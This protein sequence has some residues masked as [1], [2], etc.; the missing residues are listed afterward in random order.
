MTV[1]AIDFSGS[2]DRELAMRAA[3][4]I[5][6]TGNAND[7]AL[8]F[9]HRIVGVVPAT[10]AA[11]LINNAGGGGTSVQKVLDW[12]NG[13]GHKAVTIYTDGW[14]H[15]GSLD[16]YDLLATV[17]LMGADKD[18]AKTTLLPVVGRIF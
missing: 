9:D 13:H 4:Q 1:Y 7:V 12:A 2:T 5:A 11:S 14:F 3:Q 15:E 17:V 16:T 10:Q 6:K 8:T 18:V